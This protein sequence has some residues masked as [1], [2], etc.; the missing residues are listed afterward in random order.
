M[1]EDG[2]HLESHK[3]QVL[4]IRGILQE[5]ENRL[6]VERNLLIAD[7]I[8]VTL[9]TTEGLVFI[10]FRLCPIGLVT[11]CTHTDNWIFVF[12]WLLIFCINLFVLCQGWFMSRPVIT[13]R[14]WAPLPSWTQR[15]CLWNPPWGF[16]HQ[17]IFFAK[18]LKCVMYKISEPHPNQHFCI[19]SVAS[20]TIKM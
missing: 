7:R 20:I 14:H 18:E 19:N 10:K 3:C 5:C 13:E 15:I 1:A 11:L 4:T 8:L 2:F 16:T 12:G 9:F 6:A 17:S